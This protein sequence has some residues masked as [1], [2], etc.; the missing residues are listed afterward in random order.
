MDMMLPR[1]SLLLTENRKVKTFIVVNSLR[2]KWLISFD[3]IPR[4]EAYL[5]YGDSEVISTET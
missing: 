1:D 2:E 4:L 5:Q 3:C